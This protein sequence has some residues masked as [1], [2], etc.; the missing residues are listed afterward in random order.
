MDWLSF[1]TNICFRYM[2]IYIYVVLIK[3]DVI[4][5]GVVIYLATP[6]LT[7]WVGLASGYVASYVVQVMRMRRAAKRI[8]LQPTRE[9]ERGGELCEWGGGGE[10]ED[11]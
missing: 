2:Y 11:G 3:V 6:T 5:S 8:E 1:I 10:I 7:L 9:R 4:G